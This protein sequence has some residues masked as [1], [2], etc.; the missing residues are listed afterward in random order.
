VIAVGEGRAGMVLSLSV[1]SQKPLVS[2]GEGARKPDVRKHSG[3][4]G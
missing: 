3:E 2:K 1:S 4:K